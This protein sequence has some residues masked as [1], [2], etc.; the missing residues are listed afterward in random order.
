M[1]QSVLIIFIVTIIMQ[2]LNYAQRNIIPFDS[3]Q[4]QIDQGEILD[5]MGRKALK[6]SATLKDITFEN[7]V[8]EVDICMDGTRTFAGINFRM[9]S[10]ANFEHFYLR[11]HKSKQV[12]ALQYTPVF[13]GIAGWQLYNGN[14]FT[15][16]AELPHNEWFHV[17]MEIK[18]SQAR[19]FL[20]NA[21][22]PAMEMKHLIHGKSKGAIGLYGPTNGAVYF[23]NFSYTS[24]DDLVFEP[25]K[26]QE[27][28]EGI[29][30]NWELS[31]PLSFYKVDLEKHP[32]DQDLEL[33]WQNV[34]CDKRG[35]VDIG[36]FTSRSGPEP[37]VIY[38]RTTFISDKDE[39]HKFK[40]GYS[41][42]V[43][44]FVN[45]QPVY[46][47]QSYFRQRDPGFQG[48]AGLFDAIYLPLQKGEN[49]IMLQVIE[50][51]GGWGFYFQDAEFV[52]KDNSITQVWQ[53]SKDINIPE[54][55][56][57]D[58]KR[59]VLYVSNYG[60]YSPP[61][62]QTISKVSLEGKVLQYDWV[63]NLQKPT[64]MQI[65]NDKLYVVDR[66]SV[67]VVNIE[68]G[69]I[70]NKLVFSDAKFPNDIVIT[71]IGDMY[72]SDND[73]HVIFKLVK[74]Q[75]EEWLT[76]DINRPNGMFIDGNKLIW[77]NNG[78]CELRSI[79]LTT[80]QRTTIAKIEDALI[81][82]IKLS[83][84]GNFIV[85]D[86]HGRIFS[87]THEGEIKLLINS[88][89]QDLKQADFEYIPEKNLIVVPSLTSNTVTAYKYEIAGE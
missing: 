38:A 82:G 74:G 51:F 86:Y 18:D 80:G 84:D 67:S 42:A 61:G 8:I 20:G 49:E 59:D 6:G 2:N 40:I 89:G 4:W 24:T 60:S 3:E 25:V 66:S 57:Y 78:T 15:N 39:M 88:K 77:G 34:Q 55:V 64:G 10:P 41:D 22:T 36:R 70:E 17:R 76:D 72:V 47:G 53:F 30:E 44:L 32:A 83:K 11:P 14:G 28:P 7:G 62:Q 69:S 63:K 12:D 71:D 19:V 1:K 35:L 79:D 37:D 27:I 85:S 46:N 9:Q 33:T 26:E 75:F 58:R 50:S 68:D 73:K 45:G 31:Q 56:V 81:D 65:Y 48:I 52:I 54:S 5:Y 29:I 23:S 13:N 87:V 21:S 16:T 43:L